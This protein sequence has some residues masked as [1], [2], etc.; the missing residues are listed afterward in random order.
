MKSGGAGAGKRKVMRVSGSFRDSQKLHRDWRQLAVGVRVVPFRIQELENESMILSCAS[1]GGTGDMVSDCKAAEETFFS[2]A[3]GCAV[4]F[5]VYKPMGVPYSTLEG[6]L[7]GIH[8]APDRLALYQKQKLDTCVITRVTLTFQPRTL[9]TRYCTVCQ[10][11][12]PA[13]DPRRIP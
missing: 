7:Q 9:Q 11:C 6:Y 10:Q 12:Q 5:K 1:G 13:P 2:K 4:P 8:R 3:D